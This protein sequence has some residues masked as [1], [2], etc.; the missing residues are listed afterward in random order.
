MLNS[1]GIMGP[2]LIS[3]LPVS[4]VFATMAALLAVALPLQL[5]RWVRV[6]SSGV[7]VLLCDIMRCLND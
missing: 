4:S 6:L 2:A 1:I 3:R 7:A 5:G